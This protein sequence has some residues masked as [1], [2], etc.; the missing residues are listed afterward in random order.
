MMNN[1][2]GHV[3][4]APGVPS[5]AAESTRQPLCRNDF[6]VQAVPEDVLCAPTVARDAD[7]VI[8]GPVSLPR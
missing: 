6:A 5:G 4:L 2:R 7:A 3:P 8:A 1:W